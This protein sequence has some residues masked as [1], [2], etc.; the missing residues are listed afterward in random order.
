MNRAER[1]PS[2]RADDDTSRVRL[3]QPDART[4]RDRLDEAT[5]LHGLG[6]HGRAIELLEPLSHGTDAVAAEALW[7]M[8]ACHGAEHRHHDAVECLEWALLE[9]RVH[10]L[11]R[12]ALLYELGTAREA[13]GDRDRAAD[14]YAAVCRRAPWFRDVLK[15]LHAVRP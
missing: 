9:T 12:V 4:A 13:L 11:G 3:R 1:A 6:A 8:A 14:C 5:A 15:R 7:L 2:N 10:E